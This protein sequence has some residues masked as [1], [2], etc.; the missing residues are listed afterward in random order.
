MGQVYYW[1]G[2]GVVAFGGMAIFL[3][4]FGKTF[5]RKNGEARAY[6]DKFFF[7]WGL[8]G[9]IAGAYFSIYGC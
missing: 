6:T 1:I 5:Y 2:K 7:F 3:F 4:A 9:L 8:F